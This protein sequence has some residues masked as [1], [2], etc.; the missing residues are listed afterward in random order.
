MTICEVNL[1]I[2]SE[3]DFME[4]FIKKLDSE[5]DIDFAILDHIASASALLFPIKKMIECVCK[6]LSKLSMKI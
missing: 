2:L 3:S 4:T 6:Y 5:P 1:P